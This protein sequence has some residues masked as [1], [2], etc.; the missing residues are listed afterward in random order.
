MGAKGG[1]RNLIIKLNPTITGFQSVA[2]SKE[3]AYQKAKA[4]GDVIESLDVNN[5][6][7]SDVMHLSALNSFGEIK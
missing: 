5:M 2:K 6:S 3:K 1:I 7:K 4:R